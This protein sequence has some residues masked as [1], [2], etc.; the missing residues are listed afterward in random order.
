MG[1]PMSSQG[2][3]DSSPR[4]QSCPRRP[5]GHRRPRS[6]RPGR[7]AIRNWSAPEAGG[8]RR[9][10]EEG[11]IPAQSVSRSGCHG[12]ET[13]VVG[14]SD[15]EL[16]VATTDAH[17][18]G[19]SRGDTP[20]EMTWQIRGG[21]HGQGEG[22]PWRHSRSPGPRIRWRA[23]DPTGGRRGRPERGQPIPRHDVGRA[24]APPQ[25][26]PAPRRDLDKRPGEHHGDQCRAQE[27]ADGSPALPTPQGVSAPANAATSRTP[28]PPWRARPPGT[29]VE[30][31]TTRR[32]PRSGPTTA[33]RGRCRP[34][35]R[36]LEHRPS[37]L[38]LPVASTE[39]TNH[40]RHQP[41]P[42]SPLAATDRQDR[43]SRVRVA[44]TAVPRAIRPPHGVTAAGSAAITRS[45]HLARGARVE[46]ATTTIHGATAYANRVGG[47]PEHRSRHVGI[48]RG[49][50]RTDDGRRAT[51]RPKHGRDPGTG[52][53]GDGEQHQELLHTGGDDG[54]HGPHHAVERCPQRGIRVG[55]QTVGSRGFRDRDEVAI[56][57]EPLPQDPRQD[58]GDDRRSH[59]ADRDGTGQVTPRARTHHR[60]GHLRMVAR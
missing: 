38:D 50:D 21:R 1:D 27:Q 22:R 46:R 59:A 39:G 56:E 31:S 5:G 19:R 36:R 2:V 60:V 43:S 8:S 28:T 6:P 16:I 44:S 58:G 41:T 14:T 20:R 55:Q 54:R 17:A 24:T 25:G 15:D 7:H 23:S 13:I 3:E 37:A 4:D 57:V 49:K 40:G 35:G 9:G 18:E 47:C 51:L 29:R 48:P 12:S 30:L 42:T 34:R 11:S 32:H 26:G 10:I 53:Q 52:D 33:S 45:G